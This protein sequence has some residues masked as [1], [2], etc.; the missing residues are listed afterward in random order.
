MS[1]K[2]ETVISF[3][4]KHP[5]GTIATLTR[6]GHP[7]LASI[8]TITMDDL[9]MYFI[10]KTKTRKLKNLLKNEQVAFMVSDER[11][12]TTVE[13]SGKAFA[14]S[15][16]ME[17]AQAFDAYHTLFSSRPGMKWLPPIAQIKSG[18]YIA[19]KIIPEH[20]TY[21]TFSATKTKGSKPMEIVLKPRFRS[22]QSNV[23]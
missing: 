21:R 2:K 14:V 16:T 5:F 6:E 20:I 4:R 22:R 19:C 8:Y 15:D 11:T 23:S 13:V 9:V 17:Y 12:L 3:L 7:E 1:T 10:T 18:V